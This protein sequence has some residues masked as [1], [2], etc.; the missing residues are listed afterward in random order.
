MGGTTTELLRFSTTGARVATAGIPWSATRIAALDEKQLFITGPAGLVGI[1]DSPGPVSKREEICSGKL[2]PEGIGEIR[3][4]RNIGGNLFVAGMG[5]QVYRRVAP[6][7]WSRSDEGILSQPTV[8]A[9]VGFNSID[10]S[11]LHDIYACGFG[12]EIGWFNGEKW[13]IF[14][15]LT[16]MILNRVRVIAP[17]NVVMCGKKGIV[18]RGGRN[19]W[20]VIQSDVISEFWDVEEF[21]G[22]IYLATNDALY[23]MDSSDRISKVPI[24]S[25][26]ANTFGSLHANHGV[27]LSV[28]KND[29]IWTTDG[30]SWQNISS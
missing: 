12:G 1:K 17:G 30:T 3:D 18:I 28:G 6:G 4:M 20:N 24:P 21:G 16:N 27:L 8:N 7:R 26:V 13:I 11:S 10:G 15:D 5:R 22:H 29:V 9:A 14:R 23:M 2:G 25:S 19:T